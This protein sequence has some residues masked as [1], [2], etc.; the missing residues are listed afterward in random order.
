MQTRM[1]SAEEL[2]Y[3]KSSHEK[4][5]IRKTGWWVTCLILVVAGLIGSYYAFLYKPPEKY[6]SW[7]KDEAGRELSD[8]VK[9]ENCPY[10]EDLDLKFPKLPNAKVSQEAGKIVVQSALGKYRDVPLR[11]ILEYFQDKGTL[12]V[13]RT[14]TLE[15]WMASKTTGSENWNFDLIQPIAFYQ[16]DHGIPYLCVS[17]SRTENNESFVGLAV[18]IR[19]AD[20]VF[21]LMKEI[22]TRYRWRAEWFIQQT[23]FFR[24]SEKFLMN[25]WE[26]TANYQKGDPVKIVAEAKTLLRSHS[27]S[28]WFK[29]EY[30]LRSALCQGQEKG[31]AECV[32]E[33]VELVR[34][35]RSSQIEYFN[36][37]KISFLL[38]KTQRNE[39][40]QKRISTDLRAVFSS[41][42]DFRYHKIR[43]DKWD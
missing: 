35:L 36:Q 18:Q 24:F 27:P 6:V 11:L 17:Y 31:D 23:A 12:T 16:K 15:K 14:V 13:E 8:I 42:E 32:G 1:A 29:A 7:P 25:H 28:V 43:Q 40:E 21:I 41:E 20:W 39:K 2:E 30:L 34:E 19:M 37:Q 38:A 3:L 33:A 22:P 26:G 5:K 4:K 9:M 10:Q